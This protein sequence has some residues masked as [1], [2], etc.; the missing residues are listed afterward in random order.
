[1][2]AGLRAWWRGLRHL[3]PRG[4][5]YIWA[6]VL[7]FLLSLPVVTAPAAWAGLVRLS[8]A[9]Y[10]QPQASLDDFWAGFRENLG[11]GAVL[12][13]ANIVIF[14]LTWANLS[15][16]RAG[17]G[18][19]FDVA[20]IVWTLALLLWVTVQL[21]LWPIFYAM[22]TPS[23]R[24][25]LRNAIVMLVLNP[26]FSLGLML[27]VG[28]IVVFSVIFFAAWPLLTG[29]ALAS[30]ATAAVFD[31]LEAAGFRKNQPS[32]FERDKIQQN[33]DWGNE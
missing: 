18:T 16:Y 10:L 32:V 28:V 26:L 5:T 4:Y 27:G 6:N 17:S 22:E 1:M 29:G 3:Q 33:P 11:R 30:V 9:A 14:G 15:A 23:M 2:F 25:A 13:A 24:G 8:R 20:R 31:R 19:P 7:W 12:A 21:Y